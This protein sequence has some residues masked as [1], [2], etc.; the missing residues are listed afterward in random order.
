MRN[1]YLSDSRRFF[2]SKTND[3]IPFLPSFHDLSPPLPPMSF[4]PPPLSFPRRRESIES[5]FASIDSRLRGNDARATVITRD[6]SYDEWVEE[7]T[8]G[9]SLAMLKRHN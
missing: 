4:S 5:P 2:I 6:Y 1:L 8:R 9:M 3:F 7:A